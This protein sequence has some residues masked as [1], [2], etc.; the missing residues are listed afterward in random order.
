VTLSSATRTHREQKPGIPGETF[1]A[2]EKS[3][4]DFDE[5]SS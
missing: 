1:S 5:T 2:A 3:S 4:Y